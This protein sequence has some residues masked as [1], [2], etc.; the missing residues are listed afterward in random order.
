MATNWSTK[1]TII[2]LSISAEKILCVNYTKVEF[3]CGLLTEWAEILTVLYIFRA[4]LINICY[5]VK[6]CVDNL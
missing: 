5:V 2:K 3:K 6:I 4:C 1:Q